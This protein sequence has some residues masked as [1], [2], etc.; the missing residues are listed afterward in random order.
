MSSQNDQGGTLVLKF[1]RERPV[2]NS[3]EFLSQNGG[4]GAR[5]IVSP[6]G[7]G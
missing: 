1:A 6:G 2:T 5:A 7:D 3:G 4:P